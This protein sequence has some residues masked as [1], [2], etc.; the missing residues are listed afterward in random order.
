MEES[1]GIQRSPHSETVA[2]AL[3]VEAQRNNLQITN[4]EMGPDGRTHGIMRDNA[5][6]PEQRVGVDPQQAISGTMEHYAAQWAQT[7]SSHYAG[8]APELERSQEQARALTLLPVEDRQMFDKIRSRTP[9]HLSDDVVA[10]ALYAAK[11][12]G[13][14]DASKIAGVDMVGDRLMVGGTTPGFMAVVDTSQPV[15]SL[16]LTVQDTLSFNQQQAIAQQQEE[17]HRQQHGQVATSRG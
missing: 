12:N 2:A 13:I 17:A 1:K 5:F 14:D 4:V 9:G 7:R 15:P 6:Q 3:L 11:N 8:N 16:Q 10:S